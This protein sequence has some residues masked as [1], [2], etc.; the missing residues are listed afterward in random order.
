MRH[1]LAIPALCLLLA[2]C[3][4]PGPADYDALVAESAAPAPKAAPAHL[5]EQAFVTADGAELPLRV[6]RPT[7]RVRAVILAVHG[8]NDYSNAFDGPA[9]M[10]AWQG[11]ETYA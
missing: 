1:G 2:A 9:T 5:T 8:F 11:V 4:A 6:W 3:A 7:G 10:L